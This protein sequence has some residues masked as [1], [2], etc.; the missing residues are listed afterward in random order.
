MCFESIWD[1]FGAG[2]IK[3]PGIK[4]KEIIVMKEV[5]FNIFPL[6]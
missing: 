1:V 2:G 6:S 3:C 5:M 4:G